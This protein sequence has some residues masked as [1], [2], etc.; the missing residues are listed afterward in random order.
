MKL[1]NTGNY[2][3]ASGEGTHI[4][5]VHIFQIAS[6]ILILGYMIGIAKVSLDCT[7]VDTM[8]TITFDKKP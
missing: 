3:S 2:E 7:H 8:I 1:Q 6:L 5:R 4:W